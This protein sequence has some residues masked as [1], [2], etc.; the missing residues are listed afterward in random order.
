MII[1]SWGDLVGNQKYPGAAQL[2]TPENVRIAVHTW[3]TKG[4]DKVLFRVD[5]FR[6]M[7]FAEINAPAGSNHATWADAT[8][9][10][11]ANGILKAALDAAKAEGIEIQMWISIFDEGCPPSV[12]YNDSASFPWQTRFT[13]D[14]PEYLAHDR[15]ANASVRKYHWGV[16]ECAYPE[17]RA[18]F[19]EEIRAFADHHDFA[20]VFLS[21]RSHSPPPEY[22][23]QFGFNEPVRAEYL[24]RHGVDILRQDFDLEKWRELRGEYLTTLLREVRAHLKSRGLKLSVGGAQG[25]HIGPPLGNMQIQWRTWVAEG[26]IDE[27]VVGHHTLERATYPNRWQRTW[28]YVQNQDAGIG[29]PPLKQALRENYGPLCRAHNVKLY[30]DIPLSNYNRTYT[31][32]TLGTGTETS[33]ADAQ[34]ATELRTLPELTGII[35]DGR[36]LSVPDPYGR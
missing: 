5:D 20:G 35:V 24:K 1:L 17:V 8:R 14:H 12:F 29:L 22:A 11:M 15:S 19:L 30:V 10:A 36:S 7:L 16:P 13:R 21:I 31:D 33:A 2:D 34:F 25:E 18:H 28:G 9:K 3:K 32:R 23:D 6:Y 27:L 4:V 26:I